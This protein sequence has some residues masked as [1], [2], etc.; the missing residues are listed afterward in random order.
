MLGPFCAEMRSPL[1]AIVSVYHLLVV[2]TRFELEEC[3][4]H[5]ITMI[6]GQWRFFV[7]RVIFHFD[8]ATLVGL[9]LQ[10]PSTLQAMRDAKKWSRVPF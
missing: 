2:D 5:E 10:A 6:K 7:A 3:F 4:L 9:S 8:S 1:H